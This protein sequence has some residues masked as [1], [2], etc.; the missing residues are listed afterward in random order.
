MKKIRTATT[1][2]LP[3]GKHAKCPIYEHDGKYYIKANKPNTSSR[4]RICFNNGVEYSEVQNF[5]DKL[6]TEFWCMPYK[7][8]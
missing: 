2:H 1:I 6:G 4:T 8:K 3:F 5:P 7:V